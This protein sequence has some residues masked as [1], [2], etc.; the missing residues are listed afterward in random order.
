MTQAEDQKADRVIRTCIAP[1]CERTF[2]VGS[3]STRKWCTIAC[4][5][6][7]KQ[8]K[9]RTS[10]RRYTRK[11]IIPTTTL[12]PNKQPTLSPNFIMKRISKIDK[13]TPAQ[14]DWLHNIKHQFKQFGRAQT[15][16]FVYITPDTEL[17]I[18]NETKTMKEWINDTR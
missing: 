11:P 14:I 18:D 2:G 7:T 5:G 8:R 9:A 12:K 16:P 1:D 4:R 15:E 17:T 10:K 6:R 3:K 13:L